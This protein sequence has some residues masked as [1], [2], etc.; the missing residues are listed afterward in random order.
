M[1]TVF[2]NVNLFTFV[3][4]RAHHYYGLSV[5]NKNL[6]CEIFYLKRTTSSFESS[7]YGAE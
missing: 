6:A 3:G 4:K 1:N 5:K 2:Q 7:A